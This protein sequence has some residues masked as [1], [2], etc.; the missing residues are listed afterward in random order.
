MIYSASRQVNARSKPSWHVFGKLYRSFVEYFLWNCCM[1]SKA[2][3]RNDGWRFCQTLIN[4]S[5]GGNGGSLLLVFF[6]KCSRQAFISPG[7]RISLIH[8]SDSSIM[9]SKLWLITF[10]PWSNSAMIVEGYRSSSLPTIFFNCH[11]L[12][13]VAW[14]ARQRAIQYILWCQH[15]CDLDN[16]VY[17]PIWE[18]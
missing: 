16:I 1:Y 6:R 8:F 4:G 15:F 12:T 7:R 10:F 11:L 17:T 3:P 13:K 5:C 9:V 18:L 2:S 14:V